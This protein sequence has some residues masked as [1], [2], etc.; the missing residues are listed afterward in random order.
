MTPGAADSQSVRL[1]KRVA[2]LVPCSRSEAERY[3]EGG[4]VRV[5]GQVVEVPQARVAPTQSVTLA[6]EASLLAL[7]P[8]TVLANVD[9]GGAPASIPV[10][11]RW[12]EDSSGLR[13][14]ATQLRQAKA[15]LPLPAGAQGLAVYSQ[16]PRIVRK[17]TE[18]ALAIEQEWV[19]RVQGQI[20]EDGLARMERLVSPRTALPGRPPLKAS[21]Q[22][23]ARLRLAFKGIDP[24]QIPWLC[25]QVGL[26]AMQG[27]RIRLG[28]L[29]L[30]GLPAGQW[31]ALMP[32][33]KF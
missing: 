9:V 26:V 3:I 17:L 31:R 27:R 22:S 28:R 16:D 1:S 5:D 23:E 25:G 7:M 13:V 8:V 21:W 33:E 4:W 30:A 11:G 2:A 15:L 14:T 20:A 12:S 24:A 10:A 29:P 6:P 19:V 18:D 32:H